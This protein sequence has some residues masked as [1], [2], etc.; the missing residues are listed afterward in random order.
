MAVPRMPPPHPEACD[1]GRRQGPWGTGQ[2][3]RRQGRG[4]PAVL[5]GGHGR[6]EDPEISEG[7]GGGQ[8]LASTPRT[9]LRQEH[10]GDVAPRPGGKRPP[11]RLR[12]GRCHWAGTTAPSPPGLRNPGLMRSGLRTGAGPPR[13]SHPLFFHG[14][15][16]EGRMERVSVRPTRLSQRKF[17]HLI[18]VKSLQTWTIL[19]PDYCKKQSRDWGQPMVRGGDDLNFQILGSCFISHTRV[20]PVTML[21]GPKRSLTFPSCTHLAEGKAENE[22][23]SGGAR[24]ASG[25]PDSVWGEA[26]AADRSRLPASPGDSRPLWPRADGGSQTVPPWAVGEARGSR[27]RSGLFP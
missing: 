26:L 3:A 23:W 1:P 18:S 25:T 12:G 9:A 24:G 8:A 6:G 4:G 15:E 7:W 13:S 10:R 27:L 16:E 14:E 17:N 2:T 22:R 19:P 11:G 20:L 5:R 21:T